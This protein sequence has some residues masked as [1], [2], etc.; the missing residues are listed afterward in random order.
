MAVLYGYQHDDGSVTDE[1]IDG[2]F[3]RTVMLYGLSLTKGARLEPWSPRVALGA[4][5]EGSCLR[6]HLHAED[7][8]R[9]TLLLDTPRH[10][11]NLA[12]AEDY[13][14]LNQWPEWWTVDPARSYAVSMPD[15]TLVDLDGARLAAGLPIA[16]AP[17]VENQLTI[18]PR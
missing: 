2:N 4:A 10:A 12:L 17:N 18:C 9:G 5:T 13:P 7:V 6:V 11:Q 3:V 16:L 8:W 14:R 1:N 15:G